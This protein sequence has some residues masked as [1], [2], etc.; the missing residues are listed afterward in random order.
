MPLTRL[1]ILLCSLTL[2]VTSNQASDTTEAPSAS[3]H[4]NVSLAC[5]AAKTISKRNTPAFT[6]AD[7]VTW[8]IHVPSAL[9]ALF[10]NKKATEV[11]STPLVFLHSCPILLTAENTGPDS[12]FSFLPQVTESE[13]TPCAAYKL[14]I[15]TL[16]LKDDSPPEVAEIYFIREVLPADIGLFSSKVP[17]TE[18]ESKYRLALEAPT[19]K[20]LQAPRVNIPTLRKNYEEQ[21]AK[22]R[23]ESN[24]WKLQAETSYVHGITIGVFAFIVCSY[25]INLSLSPFL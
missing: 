9:I 10:D 24:A 16:C 12:F 17:F 18:V 8:Q 25:F 3:I 13:A 15:S 19:L 14:H 23:K 7:N 22:I 2:S 6:D 4:F 5:A 11:S 20:L 1:F 21:I